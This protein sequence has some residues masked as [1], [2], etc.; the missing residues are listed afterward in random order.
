M[1]EERDLFTLSLNCESGFNWLV[2][3]YAFRVHTSCN[4]NDFFRH[5]DFLFLDNLEVADH[6]YGSVRSKKSKLVKLV[7]FEELILNFDD[8]FFTMGFARKVDTDGN[9]IFNTLKVKDVEG[10][11][12]V[13]RWNMV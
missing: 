6:I 3:S 4:A 8:A 12:Y 9:L 5:V 1:A 2:V 11:I 10:L 13:F 7:V